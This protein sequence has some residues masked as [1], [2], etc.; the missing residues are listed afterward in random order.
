V[1]ERGDPIELSGELGAR[2]VGGRQPGAVRKGVD[3]G[4]HPRSAAR[5]LFEKGSHTA[6]RGEVQ[7]PTVVRP[8]GFEL[9]EGAHQGSEHVVGQPVGG[10][11]DTAYGTERAAENGQMGR[12][13]P[14]G[15]GGEPM[16]PGGMAGGAA[17]R[18]LRC[19][20]PRYRWAG[21]GGRVRCG[22]REVL[23]AQ[24]L[25]TSLG[26]QQ[27]IAGEHSGDRDPGGTGQEQPGRGVQRH[28]DAT[29]AQ[30]TDDGDGQHPLLPPVWNPPGPLRTERWF[31]HPRRTT[32]R[33]G[34]LVSLPG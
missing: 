9:R 29:V 6:Q 30:P 15:A 24:C 16:R 5:G 19:C 17:H 26:G 28:P 18:V 25:Q 11:R 33:L 13:E 22:L 20:G 23:P 10:L 1:G 3:I 31:L 2:P 12:R 27:L 14:G 7:V 21:R 4:T 34:H 8:G 32:A